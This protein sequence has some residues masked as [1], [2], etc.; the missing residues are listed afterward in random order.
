[1]KQLARLK[2]G[3]RV[4]LDGTGLV[5]EGETDDLSAYQSVKS[6]LVN[7]MPQGIRLKHEKVL[8]PAVKPYLWLANLANNQLQLE[9]YVPSEG[10]R[11]EIVNAAK[12]ALPTAAIV[13]RMQPGS[14]EPREYLGAVATVL[15]QLAQLEEGATELKDNQLIVTGLAATQEIAA[16]VDSRLKSDVPASIKP[17]LQ[18]GYRE[19]SVQTVSPFTT[20]VAIDAGKVI[21]SGFIPS[22]DLRAAALEAA[23]ELLAGMKIEDGLQVG[24]GAPDGWQACFN[25]GLSGLGRLGNGRFQMTDRAMVFFGEA[26][27]GAHADAVRGEVQAAANGA[28]DAEFKV[29][30]TA[31]PEPDAGSGA[32]QEAKDRADAAAAAAAEEAAQSAEEERMRAEAEA[33]EQRLRAEADRKAEEERLRAEADRKAEE[34][35]LRAEAN[36]KAEEERKRAEAERAAEQAQRR[37]E[38]AAAQRLETAALQ[39]AEEAGRCQQMLSTTAKSGIIRFKRAS[40]DLERASFPTLNELARIVSTCPGVRVEIE[41]HTD[42]EGTPARNKLLSQRRAQS[43][44]N[45]LTRAGVPAERLTAVGYGETRPVAPNDTIEHRA[46]NRRI[47]FAVTAN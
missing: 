44:A 18:I 13:D 29:S 27:D 33:E 25:A 12:K 7:H 2:S 37:A 1:L 46:R 22:D 42:A 16:A 43:V 35:R 47:E 39:R 8:P 14:G 5:I 45:Y 4:D 36:R 6:A 41:G 17:A 19:A 28:C 3:A 21:L 10:A 23:N 40:A 11:E 30:V 26:E 38:Q 34:E 9:G 24:G 31:P 20:S 32:E 15:A